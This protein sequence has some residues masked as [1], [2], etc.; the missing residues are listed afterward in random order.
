MGRLLPPEIHL[1]EPAIAFGIVRAEL[2]GAQRV[3][4][5]EIVLVQLRGMAD[6]S[7]VV[8]RRAFRIGHYESFEHFQSFAALRLQREHTL[9]AEQRFDVPRSPGNDLSK[10]LLGCRVLPEL[11]LGLAQNPP[12]LEIRRGLSRL[13]RPPC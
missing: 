12:H 7:L 8:V 10:G 2:D 6:H 9:E 11:E 4:E 13:A 1:A 5:R 3:L